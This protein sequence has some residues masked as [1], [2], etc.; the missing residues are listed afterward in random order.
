M[1]VAQANLAMPMR[2]GWLTRIIYSLALLAFV[3]ST[4]LMSSGWISI[5]LGGA[6]EVGSEPTFFLLMTGVAMFRAYQVLRYQASLDARPPN[7]LGWLCRCLGWLFMC[8][9]AVS[10]LALLAVTPI[11]HLLFKSVGDTGIAYF[12]VGLTLVVLASFGWLGCVVFEVSRFCGRRL[13]EGATLA[14]SRRK[15]DFVVLGVLLT[16]ALSISYLHRGLDV[17]PCG[18]KNLA[19]CASTTQ[20]EVRRIIGLPFGEPVIL[21]S[22]I[23]EI[24][25]RGTKGR[26]WS[27]YETPVNSLRIAGYPAAESAPSQVR[28][29]IEAKSDGPAVSVELTVFH[30]LVETARFVTIFPSGAALEK[31]ADGRTRIV[32][33]L[34]A[35]A[36]PGLRA[37]AEDSKTGRQLVRDQF[38]I[39]IRSALGSETEAREWEMRVRRPAT[40][41][42]P[43]T[44]RAPASKAFWD[45]SIDPAC[46]G[47]LD[48]TR[49]KEPA[50]QGDLLSPLYAVIFAE[51]GTL[52]PHAL[53]A[54]ILDVACRERE[55]WIVSYG[56]RRP[57]LRIRRYSA[58]G[59]LLLFVDTAIP[60]LNLNGTESDDVD[61]RSLREENGRIRFERVVWSVTGGTNVKK[62]EKKRELFEVTP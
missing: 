3:P 46:K 7:A 58:Q 26:K 24:E 41:I 52:G 10:A 9:G 47:K 1:Q 42:R 43:S 56:P 17:P 54:S 14:L 31:T 62:V 49:A 19:A 23:E 34:P 60:P 20:G 27:L 4:F 29:R 12:G 39:Q 48:M 21:D 11:T 45:G 33:D 53:T 13:P 40:L 28:V 5:A 6:T 22:I 15:Q 51:A 61:A 38:F 59:K 18:E 55:I 30:R 35:N 8:V 36:A 2:P 44:A 57:E 25:M 50:F 37:M 32:V 16:A